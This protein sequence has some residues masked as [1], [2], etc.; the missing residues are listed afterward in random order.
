MIFCTRDNCF[1]SYMLFTLHNSFKDQFSCRSLKLSVSYFTIEKSDSTAVVCGNGL[2][3]P[4][5]VIVF[6]LNLKNFLFEEKSFS[7]QRLKN[8]VYSSFLG[9]PL[10]PGRSVNSKCCS[11]IR[12]TVRSLYSTPYNTS[13]PTG[14]LYIRGAR[15]RYAAYSGFLVLNEV[16]N[17]FFCK[18]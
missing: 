15:S 5:V 6:S 10:P 8:D 2:A 17:T 12:C 4:P 9:K 14:S 16:A 11:L 7:I 13:H 1:H 18:I 3:S